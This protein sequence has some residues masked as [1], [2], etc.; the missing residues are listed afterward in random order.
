M[1]A[2]LMSLSLGLSANVLASEAADE[3]QIR[4]DCQT[5]GQAE[6]LSGKDLEEF[7]ARCVEELR[8]AKLIN[9]VK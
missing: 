3:R 6:G 9:V 5:E 2:L 4:T 1:K 7:I 8:S